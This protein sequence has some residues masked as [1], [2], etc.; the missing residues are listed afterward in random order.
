MG[1]PELFLHQRAWQPGM[2]KGQ[3]CWSGETSSVQPLCC[4]WALNQ[5]LCV[6]VWV[7][8]RLEDRPPLGRVKRMPTPLLGAGGRGPP[9]STS[10]PR[11]RHPIRPQPWPGLSLLGR[12]V[13]HFQPL[14]SPPQA[15]LPAKLFY[16]FPRITL[17]TSPLSLKPPFWGLLHVNPPFQ[18]TWVTPNPSK[19]PEPPPFPPIGLNYFLLAS[20]F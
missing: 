5:P 1:K 4:S 20:R 14:P 18:P 15:V 10:L 3:V 17:H 12:A 19:P 11:P 13:I 9:R 16:F 7:A 8:A 2:L 6:P